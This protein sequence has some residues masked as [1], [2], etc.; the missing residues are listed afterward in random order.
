[1]GPRD[2]RSAREARDAFTIDLPKGCTIEGGER[3]LDFATFRVNC[4]AIAEVGIYT[5]NSPTIVQDDERLALRADIPGRS[6]IVAVKD[7]DESTRG[8]VWETPYSWPSRLHVWINPALK[9]DGLAKRIAASVLPTNPA[10]PH[11]R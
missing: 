6:A 7:P 8:Y 10:A 5:G 3:R 4:G 2:V 11:L 9:D 1:M